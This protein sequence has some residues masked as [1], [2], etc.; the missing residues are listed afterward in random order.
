MFL[1]QFIN[2][3]TNFNLGKGNITNKLISWSEDP[4]KLQNYYDNVIITSVYGINCNYYILDFIKSPDKEKA[5]V[6]LKKLH[7]FFNNEK[8]TFEEMIQKL[9]INEEKAN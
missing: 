2:F 1:K 5:I 3:K 9:N 6:Y 8:T 4:V 7:Q